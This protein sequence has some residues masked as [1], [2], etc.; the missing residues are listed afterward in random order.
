M[1][2]VKKTTLNLL[3]S[4]RV[5]ILIILAIISIIAINPTF[6]N[7]GVAIRA[8]MVDSPASHANIQTPGANTWPRSLEVIRAINMEPLENLAQYHSTVSQLTP[9][10]SVF[11]TTN[12]G[13]YTLTVPDIAANE[14]EIGRDP[15][16]LSVSNVPSSNLRL[17][18]D[19]QGG[20]RVLIE[21]D[22]HLSAEEFSS[23]RDNLERR[24]NVFGLSDIRVR[25]VNNMPLALG[26]EPQYIL[27]EIAG[28]NIEEVRDLVN[29][30]GVFEAQIGNQTVF[31][32]EERD[33]R[34]VARTPPNAGLGPGACQQNA[35][36]ICPYFFSVTLSSEAADRFADITRPLEVVIDPQTGERT[37][38]ERII[39]YLDGHVTNNLS[40]APELR[41]SATTQIQISGSGEG[42]TQFEAQQA[43]LLDMRQMQTVIETGSLPTTITIVKADEISPILGQEFLVNAAF[44]GLMAILTVAVVVFIRYRRF[45]VSIPMAITAF[46]EVLIVLG[47]SIIIGWQ[48][49]LPAIAGLVIIIGTSV[50]HQIVITDE[51]ISGLGGKTESIKRRMKNAFFIITA[52]YFTTVVAMIP[53][54]FAGAGML[55]NF[56]LTTIIGLTVGVFISRPAFAKILEILHRR[57]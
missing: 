50:D 30:Q 18:L 4:A 27:L 54:S 47:A 51:V 11:I 9:N 12:R 22:T 42:V 41:G 29:T 39:F 20:T 16:G 23:L 25:V 2:E 35:G 34:Y 33:I 57:E 55:K 15:L 5:W 37:L 43:A 48:L 32:G 52:A 36:W 1:K 14:T 13:T 49:D 7:D 3:S 26:G 44:A 56:A 28:A 24:L 40:I 17:G 53:L 21:P 6:D 45:I 8:V 46:T 19:L 38:S 31:R 10:E